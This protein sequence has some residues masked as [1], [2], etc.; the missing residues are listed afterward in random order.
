MQKILK[1]QSTVLKSIHDFMQEKEIIQ[2]LPVILSSI[3][4]PLG[5][6]PDTE[7]VKQPRIQY[8]QQELVLCQSMIFHKQLALLTDVKG[9]YTISPNIRLEHPRRGDTGRHLFEFCQVDFELSRTGMQK[10]MNFIEHLFTNIFADVQAQCGK[11]M[12][13]FNRVLPSPSPPFPRFTTHEVKQKY[14]K[15]WEKELSA[16]MED[17]FWVTCHDREFYDKED[18]EN[19]GHFKN[20]DLI[21]PEGYGEALSG[22][23]REYEYTR[24]VKR[25]REDGMPLEQYETFLNV[26]KKGLIPST[27]AGFG[28][29][30][31]IR[32]ITGKK[33][34]RDVKLFPKV[35]GDPVYF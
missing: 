32:F 31:L 29:E 12:K 18:P 9:I 19:P 11:T 26:A 15:E 34:I 25:L 4:D 5:S 3:T 30:R 27:G 23:E 24:I 1:I 2:I 16:E 13:E 8:N 7:L 14:G 20:Y 35:P 33:E 10:T 22:G 21:Y 28:V 17:F 6:D